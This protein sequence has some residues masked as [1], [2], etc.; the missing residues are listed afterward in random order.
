MAED[1]PW[2]TVLEVAELLNVHS[3]TV[4]RLITAGRLPAVRFGGPGST[5]R[6]A[7]HDLD[8]FVHAARLDPTPGEPASDDAATRPAT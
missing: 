4:R 5:I 2:L 1:K 8:A 6:I 3:N 7:T